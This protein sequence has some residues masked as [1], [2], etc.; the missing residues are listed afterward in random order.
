MDVMLSPAVAWDQTAA[1]GAP[2]IARPLIADRYRPIR[3]L[4]STPTEQVVVAEHS[5]SGR[6]RG[7]G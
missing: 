7:S 5:L 3:E 1:M 6:C 2:L 4:R